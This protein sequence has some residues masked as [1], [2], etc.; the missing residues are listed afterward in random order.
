MLTKEL[1]RTA[2]D[3]KHAPEFREPE[4]WLGKPPKKTVRIAFAASNLGEWETGTTAV[5]S[6]HG[7]RFRILC[8]GND[9]PLIQTTRG[10]LVGE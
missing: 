8:E 4:A 6:W 1:T 7:K 9:V 5:I 3:S 10:I 2:H